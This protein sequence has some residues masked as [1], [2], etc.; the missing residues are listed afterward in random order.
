MKSNLSKENLEKLLKESKG[1]LIATDN[2]IAVEGN[3]IHILGNFAVLVNQLS[4]SI[5][6]DKL[7]YAFKTGLEENSNNKVDV[8]DEKEAKKRMKMMLKDFTESLFKDLQ[9][10]LGDDD[11]E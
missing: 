9:E 7:E 3:L 8:N 6:K 5:S 10:M 1:T 11:N 4:N 2:G